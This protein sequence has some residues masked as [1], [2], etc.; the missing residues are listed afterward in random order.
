MPDLPSNMQQ[1]PN[2]EFST[3][4]QF[5]S[6]LGSYLTG[7]IIGFLLLGTIYLQKHFAMQR[8]QAK[9]DQ[10]N[11]QLETPTTEVTP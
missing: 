6:K 1:S 7:V 8:E 11:S 3:P 5:R 10:Q 9:Q 2:N 4:S